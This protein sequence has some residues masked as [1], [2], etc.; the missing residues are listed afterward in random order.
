[1]TYSVLYNI[2]TDNKIIASRLLLVEKN[3]IHFT[4]L[5]CPPV[6]GG[7]LKPSHNMLYTYIICDI[8]KNYGE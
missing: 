8:G 4:A 1:M 2:I 5:T 6:N 7:F 3:K